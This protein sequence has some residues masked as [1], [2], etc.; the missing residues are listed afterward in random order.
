LV[1]SGGADLGSTT[2]I[3]AKLVRLAET[4]QKTPEARA[5]FA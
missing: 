4:A 1:V 2:G 5:G 3:D